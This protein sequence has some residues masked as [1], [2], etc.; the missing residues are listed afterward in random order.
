MRQAR[1]PVDVSGRGEIVGKTAP[2]PRLRTRFRPSLRTRLKPSWLRAQ[3]T[4]LRTQPKLR[5]RFKQSAATLVQPAPTQEAVESD[6]WW[7]WI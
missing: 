5:T 7:N 2:Q 6:D 4:R 3:S 1:M